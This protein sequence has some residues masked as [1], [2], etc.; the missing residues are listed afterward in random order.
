MPRIESNQSVF[1]YL[2][3][4]FSTVY[5]LLKWVFLSLLVGTLVGSASAGFLVSL[6]F[7]TNFR[8]QNRWIIVFLPIAGFV[9]GYVYYTFGKN[10]EAGNNLLLD[11]LHEPA[12]SQRIP[13]RMAV[14]V[15]LG[16]L[17]THL[18]GGSAG[19][20]GTALQM[21]G[22]ISDQLSKPFR[23]QFTDRKT[24]LLAALAAGFGS[25]FG[26][27]LA[28]A[29]FALEFFR[30]GQMTYKSLFPVFLAS[31]FASFITDSW[32]VAHT[33][34]SISSVPTFT[35]LHLFYI[36]LA[37]VFFGLCAKFYSKISHFTSTF[38]ATKTAYPPLRPVVGGAV[39]A[40]AV[41]ML[42]TTDYIGLG[43]PTIVRS[44]ETQLPFYAFLLKIALTV[45]T[46]S[47]GFKGGEVTPLFFI[48]ATLGNAL[49]YFI[50]LPLALLAGTG[51]VAV[52]AGATNTPLACILMGIE[53]F[54]IE[55]GVYVALAC[56]VAY[57]VSGHTGIYKNQKIG[58][59]KLAK[60]EHHEDKKVGEIS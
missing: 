3:T 24:L 23:L 1:T 2:E 58:T 37:G 57:L 40:L 44:F 25:V 47:S 15:Y 45:I 56:V 4:N 52:F 43:I 34:Y 49:A 31:I 35:L 26:T 41:F 30:A 21:A 22:A 46:L 5:Y 14:F 48:G 19:R 13:F 28:G 50:P 60:N 33:H 55:S 9:V 59:S 38:F 17:I 54:G 8:E 20:E 6:D 29:V 11:T 7:I 39:V 51:F 18:F 27:P 10:A 53:L 42:D 36:L 32:Q 12:T 16:T